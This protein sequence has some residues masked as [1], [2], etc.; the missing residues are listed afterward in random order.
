MSDILW[1]AAMVYHNGIGGTGDIRSVCDVVCGSSGDMYG[2]GVKEGRRRPGKSKAAEIK[3]IIN[4][5][6]GKRRN[7]KC[8]IAMNADMN[9][10]C[11]RDIANIIQRA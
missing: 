3:N 4:N 8:I 2:D 5:I 11:R 7:V 6:S 1:I 9:L 10:R